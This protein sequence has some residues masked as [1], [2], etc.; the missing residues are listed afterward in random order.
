[1]K[2]CILLVL[3]ITS[4]TAIGQNKSPMLVPGIK[5]GTV[6]SMLSPGY[7]DAGG[8]K[9]SFSRVGGF[10]M[11]GF[12]QIRVGHQFII[13]PE[14]FFSVKGTRETVDYNNIIGPFSDPLRVNYLEFPVNFLVKI[15]AGGG[16]ITVGGGPSPAFTTNR[17]VNFGKDLDFGVNALA[18]YQFTSGFGFT[19]N[20]T[21]GLNNMLSNNPY[22]SSNA[23]SNSIGF[24]IGYAF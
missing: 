3:L 2:P 12:L 15:P 9:H 6:R 21:Q 8:Y 16:F 5:I 22:G 20:Y 4:I 18:S 13:Q 23:K 7:T 11:G 19:I 10:R 1:M 24:C 17:Y 14:I